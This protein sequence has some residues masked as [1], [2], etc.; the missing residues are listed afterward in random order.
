[1]K[2]TV[3]IASEIFLQHD[4]G[5]GHPERPDRY[6]AVMSLF[7]KNNI[8]RSEDVIPPRQATVDELLLCHTSE[9][10]KCVQKEIQELGKGERKM[11][12]TGDVVISE[13]SYVAALFAVGACLVAVDEVF[14]K[15][16]SNAF[17]VVRP[18]GHH[19]CSSRGMGFCLFNN[20]AIAC[21]Y[22]MKKYGIQRALIVDWDVHHGN[23]TQEIFEQDPSVFYFSVHQKGIY[24]GTGAEQDTGV[25]HTKMNCPI[26]PGKQSRLDVL[27]AFQ[28]KLLP[29]MKQFRPECVFISAG[30][31]AH[32]QDPL[33]GLNLVEDDFAALTLLVR[34]IAELYAQDRIISILEGGY[35]LNALA[36]SALAHVKALST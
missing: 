23:G 13:Q 19:A 16:A 12:S 2:K 6:T 36:Y 26:A 21:R 5:P 30:F 4:T 35:H 3:C 33:G 10:I 15:K 8:L 28:D 20:V 9:Y 11:L 17:C 24:P 25:N 31:D 18:P 7:L 34:Q 1:M 27:A 32:I 14:Q 29:A 22:A